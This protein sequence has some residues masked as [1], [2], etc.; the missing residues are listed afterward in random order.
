MK[1]CLLTNNDPK[2]SDRLVWVNSVDP[3][4]T[5]PDQSLHYFRGGN[6]RSAKPLKIPSTPTL[7]TKKIPYFNCFNH[8]QIFFFEKTKNKKKNK[9]KNKTNKN[10][11]KQKKQQQQPKILNSASTSW[12]LPPLMFAIQL[13]VSFG[14]ISLW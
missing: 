8:D 13:L 11:K 14:C 7:P 4:Q 2:F 3:D 6:G 9:K 10:K 1:A 12:K 5:A